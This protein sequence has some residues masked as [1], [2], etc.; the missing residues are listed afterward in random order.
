V[1]KGAALA[2]VRFYKR[3]I[4]PSLPPGCRYQ[5]TCS[6]YTYEAIERHGVLRGIALGAWRLARCN[7]FAKGGVDPVPGSEGPHEAPPAG[8]RAR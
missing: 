2:A 7:P 3:N 6:E 1:L 4:S 8:E 5:P